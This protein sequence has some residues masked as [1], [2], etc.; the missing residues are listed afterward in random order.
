[1][2][3][4][5]LP[6]RLWGTC[7]GFQLIGVLGANFSRTLLT[8]GWDS[9]NVTLPVAWTTDAES[10]RLWGDVPDVRAV[11]ANASSPVAINMH[12]AGISPA[13]FAESKPLSSTFT[14]LGTSLD[15]GG[16]EFVATMESK[17]GNVYA[18][19][20]H[21]EKPAVRA[22]CGFFGVSLVA[23][24]GEGVHHGTCYSEPEFLMCPMHDTAASPSPTPQYEWTLTETAMNHGRVSI[25]TN[26]YPSL[27]FVD[28]ARR[29]NRAFAT[30]EA[31][32]AA[33]IY[34]YAATDSRTI[35]SGF[36]QV[37]ECRSAWLRCAIV[38]CHFEGT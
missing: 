17:E 18:T 35:S 36:E 30:P 37:R 21:P 13:S 16:K 2:G 38:G 7:L 12:Q 11:Y 15:R 1:M 5:S 4:S 26:G 31:E 25:Q 29:N 19:Q 22:A 27:F 24:T 28:V 34:S 32:A 6:C 20:W 23:T 8:T 3:P 10:S 14:I 33:L 9:E